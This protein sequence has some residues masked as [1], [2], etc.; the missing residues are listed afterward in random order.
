MN[1]SGKLWFKE[2]SFHMNRTPFTRSMKNS[3]L[4]HILK[5]IFNSLKIH[6]IVEPLEKY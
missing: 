3:N 1:N 2:M 4:L 6:I 5:I